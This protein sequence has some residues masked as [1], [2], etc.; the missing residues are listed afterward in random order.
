MSRIDT[1]APA[2]FQNSP[3]DYAGCIALD[4]AAQLAE[5]VAAA[6]CLVQPLQAPDLPAFA[7]AAADKVDGM[8]KAL[9]PPM[10][11]LGPV[12]LLASVTR[13]PSSIQGYVVIPDVAKT[14]RL[15]P[16]PH[17]RGVSHRWAARV[18]TGSLYTR[19]A[20]TA[21][22]MQ[23]C[24]GAKAVSLNL[25]PLSQAYHV[26]PEGDVPR[27]AC[28]TTGYAPTVVKPNK[29]PNPFRS[30]PS[31]Y[32]TFQEPCGASL[33]YTVYRLLHA[34]ATGSLATHILP[35]GLDLFVGCPHMLVSANRRFALYLGGH[36]IS[37][38]AALSPSLTQRC[39]MLP[40]NTYTVWSI[41]TRGEAVVARLEDGGDLVVYT[42][43]SPS[44]DEEEVYRTQVASGGQKPYALVLKDDGSLAAVDAQNADVTAPRFA[45]F[46]EDAMREANLSAVTVGDADEEDGPAWDRAEF[47]RRIEELKDYL[48][49]QSLLR[50]DDD[51]H[52][53]PPAA[54]DPNG[55]GPRRALPM[56][57]MYV[58]EPSDRPAFDARAED[59]ARLK[60]LQDYLRLRGLLTSLAEEQQETAAARRAARA[61]PSASVAG[62]AA[63]VPPFRSGENYAARLA[64]LEALLRE[65]ARYK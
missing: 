48:R 31:W 50:D 27:R 57:S 18:L 64:E 37:L 19:P 17:A 43:R 21:N 7:R 10:S 11:N 24:P 14:G 29:P 6:P 38:H 30:S 22:C 26:V 44:A 46:T 13:R 41:G 20:T 23:A 25:G 51:R 55:G 9:A 60:N 45:R 58:Y 32:V 47:V 40:R 28:T 62:T 3:V 2:C 65:N 33:H 8:V 39:T 15:C 42:Q 36:R 63:D 56:S 54:T 59:A 61:T 34:R 1:A 52:L 16:N 5:M 49:V 53:F 35:A 12:F 4:S